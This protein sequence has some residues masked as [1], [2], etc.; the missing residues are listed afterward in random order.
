MRVI[1][2]YA[3]E[4]AA[5]FMDSKT[6]FTWPTVQTDANYEL[7][8]NCDLE[9]LVECL[10]EHGKKTVELVGENADLGQLTYVTSVLKNVSFRV[11]SCSKPISCVGRASSKTWD[12]DYMLCRICRT[13]PLTPWSWYSHAASD[14]HRCR[15]DSY[16]SNH[17]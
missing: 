1:G 15:V 9:L 2:R 4:I 14:A 17:R 16:L 8:S 7:T 5:I 13:G 11:L 3:R 12:G 6:V 10:I